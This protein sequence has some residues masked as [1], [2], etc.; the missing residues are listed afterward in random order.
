MKTTGKLRVATVIP[1]LNEAAFVADIVTRASRYCDEVIVVDDGS[2]DGTSAVAE[3]AGARVV[4]HSSRQGAGAATRSGF[5]AA[6][7]SGADI[8][9][10]L[11]GDGQ[12]NPDEIPRLLPPI[13]E[14][15]ADF[16]I[17]SR[18]IRPDHNMPVHR[19]FGIDVI[20]L[21]YNLGSRQQITDTQSGFRAHSRRLLEAVQITRNDFGFSVEMLVLARKKGFPIR[22]VPISCVYHSQ[23]SSMNPVMHGLS[24]ALSVAQLR[25]K[26]ELF[27]Q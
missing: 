23:G 18:F 6:L 1:C 3:A 17:G 27:G 25:I 12:H 7:R 14:G 15:K 19:E 8:V 4:R 24:V 5:K 20:N 13:Q 22:E 11:D 16:V 9:V 21:M 10:T 26:H 2:T